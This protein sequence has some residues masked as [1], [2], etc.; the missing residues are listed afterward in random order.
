MEGITCGTGPRKWVGEE[1]RSSV[2]PPPGQAT[3]YTD[4]TAPPPERFPW[5]SQPQNRILLHRHRGQAAV[6]EFLDRLKSVLADRYAIEREIGAG[7]M[8]IV[9]LAECRLHTCA[10]SGHSF[11]DPSLGLA[12]PAFGRRRR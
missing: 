9:Y 1:I 8:A 12:F 10:S 4:S 2:N 5:P 11:M 3:L 6:P 7:G